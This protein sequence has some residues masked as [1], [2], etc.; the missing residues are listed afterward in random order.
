MAPEAQG[1]DE[2]ESWGGCWLGRV[3]VRLGTSI[4]FTRVYNRQQEKRP[5]SQGLAHDEKIWGWWA[6]GRLDQEWCCFVHLPCAWVP[7]SPTASALALTWTWQAIPPTQGTAV[8]MWLPHELM[9]LVC[10]SEAGPRPTGSI[11]NL[12]LVPGGLCSDSS[13]VSGPMSRLAPSP[14]TEERV[15]VPLVGL[16]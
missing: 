3:N 4:S 14:S 1:S 8:C 12:S 7:Q 6:S 15:A 10:S 9:G 13:M 2:S 16:E 5:L 11:T